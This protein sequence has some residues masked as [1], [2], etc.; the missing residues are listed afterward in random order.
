MFASI[1]HFEVS[2][3][4]MTA[5]LTS[6]FGDRPTANMQ[7]VPGTNLYVHVNNDEKDRIMIDPAYKLERLREVNEKVYAFQ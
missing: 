3:E 5:S 6:I 2:E 1:L 4:D 7:T